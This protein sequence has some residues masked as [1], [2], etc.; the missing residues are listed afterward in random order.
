MLAERSLALDIHSCLARFTPHNRDFDRYVIFVAV[1]TIF[2]GFVFRCS[3][4]ASHC[5]DVEAKNERTSG[6]QFRIE[7]SFPKRASIGRADEIVVGVN[8]Q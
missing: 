5:S 3:F 1:G 2:F 7:I 6:D 4:R 8:Q